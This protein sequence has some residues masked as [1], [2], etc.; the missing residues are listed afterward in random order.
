MEGWILGTP[1][2]IFNPYRDCFW[3]NDGRSRLVAI[4]Q[5]V[6]DEKLVSSM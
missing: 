1:C 5:W 2:N 6:E 4:A 3:G